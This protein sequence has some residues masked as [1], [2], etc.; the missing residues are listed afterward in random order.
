MCELAGNG[1]PDGYSFTRSDGSS[2]MPL[3]MLSGEDYLA[4]RRWQ[5]SG[6]CVPAALPF[7]PNAR[8]AEDEAARW[9]QE[10]T[11]P[12]WRGNRKPR[13]DAGGESGK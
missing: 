8:A 11:V 13:R 12:P 4:R 7:P 10:R 3:S 2:E 6:P 1:S 9:T 5:R